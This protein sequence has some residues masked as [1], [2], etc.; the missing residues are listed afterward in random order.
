M[1]QFLWGALS[2]LCIVA[3]L[4]FLSFWRRTK[5]RLFAALSAGFGLLALH[6][7][8]LGIVNPGS[9]T[10]HYLYVVRF[11]AFA[12]IIWGVID[13]NRATTPRVPGARQ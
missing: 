11:L 12:V 8:G 9:E 6:W 10:R 2:S 4:F 13:K 7:A 3:C 1:N 5:D